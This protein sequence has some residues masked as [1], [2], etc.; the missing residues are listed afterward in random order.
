[1]RLSRFLSPLLLAGLVASAA[2]GAAAGGDGLLALPDPLALS[3]DRPAT[4]EPP[5]KGDGGAAAAFVAEEPPAVPID[6]IPNHRQML[7]DIVL[8]L[9]R[10]AHARDPDFVLVARGGLDLLHVGTR[11]ARWAQ[12]AG[13]EVGAAGAPVRPYLRAVDGVVIDGWNC[14]RRA[15]DTATPD[16]DRAALRHFAEMVAA[17]QGTV[18]AIDHCRAETSAR[19][20]RAG[21]APPLPVHAADAPGPFLRRI[22][23]RRP[24][25]ENAAPVRRLDQ[26]RTLLPVLKAD[27]NVEDWLLALAETNH[28]LLIIDAFPDGT[29]LTPAQVAALKHKRL[30]SRRMVLAVVP[31]ARADDHMP[32]WKDDWRPGDPEWLGAPHEQRPGATRPLFWREEWKELLGQHFKAAMD[33]GFDGVLLDGLDAHRHFEAGLPLPPPPEEGS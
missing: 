28:D 14:G 12:L 4:V 22:P 11:E 10:Y 9:A 1:M 29:V 20:A 16:S 13:A 8:E 31:V 2:G 17:A 18:L 26:V 19:A 5:P 33:L 32:Y 30:G 27:R 15:F 7:R 25:G 21:E 3:Y 23:E 24:S 6:D